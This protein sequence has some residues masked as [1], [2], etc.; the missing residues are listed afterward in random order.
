M[1]RPSNESEQTRAYDRMME[2][3]KS[4]LEQTERDAL[5][6]LQR[7]I[8]QAK[9]TAVELGE[10]TRDEAEQ[11]GEWLRRD[12]QDAGDYLARTGRDLGAWLKFDVE[13]VEE[14][15]LELL[16]KAADQTHLQ[17]FDVEER[18]ERATHYSA[19]EV[20]GPGTLECS[21]C[22]KLLH[23]HRTGHVPPCPVCH[24]GRFNRVSE[25]KSE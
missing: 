22:G 13:L 19:G 14:R 10:L 16:S 6:P 15:F 12:L 23:M 8:E 7:S 21:A 11:I 3:V 4:T 5:P 1:T 17:L 9:I 25:E 20:T 24:A 2:R 18:A